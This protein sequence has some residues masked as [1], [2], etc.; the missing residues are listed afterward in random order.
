VNVDLVERMEFNGDVRVHIQVSPNSLS[1][2]L[3]LLEAD[4]FLPFARPLLEITWANG[5]PIVLTLTV[6]VLGDKTVN[7]GVSLV[8]NKDCAHIALQETKVDQ[9]LEVSASST[10]SDLL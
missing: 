3:V 10:K 1:L 5:E 9:T 8:K 2:T 7:G 4:T 6:A